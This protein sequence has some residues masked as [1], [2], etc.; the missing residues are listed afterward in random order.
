MNQNLI[1]ITTVYVDT[2]PSAIANLYRSERRRSKDVD[3]SQVVTEE[4]L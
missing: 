3:R 2:V 1:K 4:N